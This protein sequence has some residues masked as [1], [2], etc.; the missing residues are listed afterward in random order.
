ML[1]NIYRGLNRIKENPQLVYTFLIA[2]FILG[3]FVVIVSRFANIAYDAQNR[4]VNIRIGSIQDTLAAFAV[5]HFEEQGM[6]SSLL[7]EVAENNATIQ[8]F[9]VIHVVDKVPYVYASMYQNKTGTKDTKHQF[10]FNIAA[11]DPANSFTV[12]ET[13]AGER[14]YVTVRAL[15]SKEGE[16]VGFLYSQ[17]S[18]S[19]AD[20]L[21]NKSILQSLLIFSFVMIFMLFL[22]FR[23]SKII[24]Y[25]SLYKKLKEVDELK[26]DF[27]SMA[28]HELRAPL[29]AIRGYT[30]LVY[31]DPHL[32]G[33]TKE[34]LRRIDISSKNL[35][36][37]VSDMLDVSRIEQGRM[38]FEFKQIQ[39]QG[40]INDVITLFK[41][42]AE[43]KKLK[44]VAS[45]A[46]SSTINADEIRLRQVI[47][48]L[49]S[50]AIK[51]TLQ[52]HVEIKTYDENDRYIIR[53][54]D[55]GIGLSAEDQ[56]KL[57]QKFSR[58]QS[59]ETQSIR[60]TGLG[61]WITHQIIEAMNGTISIESIKGT[62]SHFIVSFPL[63][64]Q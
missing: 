27:I 11:A 33:E 14:N 44:L 58:I 62:G 55:T 19:E 42:Q 8:E 13:I 59:P 40:I 54:S 31:D 34:Y 39:P 63:K 61:L 10:L 6:L 45:L 18:L 47:T 15:Q 60:G 22:F 46:S 64:R 38:K 21:V 28:S 4:L 41:P 30:E 35:D 5:S 25:M 7:Q 32:S 51:Y 12:E 50:N 36:G 49:V 48:N 37:L 23:H 53:I 9:D 1:E 26:D 29:T 43:E 20:R 2:I 57:F 24:D 52:G 17:Q 56:K 3:A 16:V